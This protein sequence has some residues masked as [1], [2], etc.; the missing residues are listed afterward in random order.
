MSLN[1]TWR[2]FIVGL[3]VAA[4]PVL[5]ITAF[6]VAE[7]G[8]S[9]PSDWSVLFLFVSTATFLAYRWRK[10]RQAASAQGQR[11][12][13]ATVVD[14]LKALF[15]PALPAVLWFVAT[16]SLLVASIVASALGY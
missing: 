2:R 7:A 14:P 4:A 1:L 12:E 9:E 11:L 10:L 15:G 3:T 16:V 5:L 8:E 6:G 13:S